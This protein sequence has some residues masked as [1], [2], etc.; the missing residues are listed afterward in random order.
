M[1]AATAHAV[2]VPGPRPF[3]ATPA[4][5]YRTA[6]LPAL[7]RYAEETAAAD[8]VGRALAVPRFATTSASACRSACLT[9]RAASA[10]ATDAE[11]DVGRVPQRS[12]SV[13]TPDSALRTAHRVVL[14]R[15]VETMVA[16]EVAAHAR[17]ASVKEGSVA[18]TTPTTAMRPPSAT[19][20]T[21]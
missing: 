4:S 5:A 12:Q 18:A 1:T 17:T 14:G 20:P 10:E 8:P 21:V 9:A 11:A 6:L 3:A 13:P 2:H 19:S 15:N 7:A 16:A